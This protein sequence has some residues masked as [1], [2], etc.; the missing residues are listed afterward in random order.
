LEILFNSIVS[1]QSLVRS[2]H[3][4]EKGR[5]CLP[6]RQGTTRHPAIPRTISDKVKQQLWQIP[7]RGCTTLQGQPHKRW[8]IIPEALLRNK[9]D[10]IPSRII[11]IF[12]HQTRAI[13]GREQFIMLCAF[14]AML[15]AREVFGARFEGKCLLDNLNDFLVGSHFV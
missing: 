10:W 7:A 8:Q 5:N 6:L 14:T 4:P 15:V 3:V 13:A 12:Q 2:H 9:T 11:D 1:V